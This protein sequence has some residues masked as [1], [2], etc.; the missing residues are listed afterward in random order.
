MVGAFPSRSWLAR[1]SNASAPSSISPSSSSSATSA[2]VASSAATRGIDVHVT[3][4]RVF[5][6][7]SE[8]LFAL[9]PASSLSHS[10][11]PSLSSSPSPSLPLSSVPLLHSS[12]SD[13]LRL[14][15]FVLQ[16]CHV[17]IVVV[18]EHDDANSNLS[19]DLASLLQLVQTALAMLPLFVDATPFHAHDT[20]H[21]SHASQRP[22]PLT[23]AVADASDPMP[24]A[25]SR[26]VFVVNRISTSSFGSSVSDRLHAFAHTC[27][28]VLFPDLQ[29][30]Y[31]A[32]E[33]GDER[34]FQV[35]DDDSDD[36]GDNDEQA[37]ITRRGCFVHGL[38]ARSDTMDHGHHDHIFPRIDDAAGSMP[39]ARAGAAADGNESTGG[40][41][42]R[43]NRRG[44]LHGSRAGRHDNVDAAAATAATAVATAAGVAAAANHGAGSD[45]SMGSMGTIGSMGSIGE[46]G[47]ERFAGACAA[48]VRAV[49][50]ASKRNAARGRVTERD[51]C[52][53]ECT[54]GFRL[55]RPDTALSRVT[56]ADPSKFFL[57]LNISL[58][59]FVFCETC[60]LFVSSH[61]RLSYA[62]RLWHDMSVSEAF[63]EEI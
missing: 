48:L 2:V 35:V 30:T 17:T 32:V 22:L 51:W 9:S 12:F 24:F 54:I 61:G 13:S 50:G 59:H 55:R 31:R 46:R 49:R 21:P 52:V 45:G 57:R 29:P 10:T 7:D 28:S 25:R 26:L 37:P 34:A 8:P 36:G 1:H 14:L 40:G 19:P 11:P 20:R 18:D 39:S 41:D 42:P 44:A 47:D 6:L 53:S 62:N 60:S 16:T 58:T 5:L 33:S 15:L 43:R 63:R 3:G 4:E 56:F 23:V 27:N 38:P